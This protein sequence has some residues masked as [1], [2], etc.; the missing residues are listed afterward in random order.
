VHS[1]TTNPSRITA[2]IAGTH[3]ITASVRWTDPA[4]DHALHIEKNATT[5]LAS[6]IIGAT[7]SF[8]PITGATTVA[9]LAAD[10]YITAVVQTTGAGMNTASAS[11]QSNLSVAF[12]GP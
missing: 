11:E 8:V 3:V 2:P 9:R 1:N 5:I 4:G 6:N 12:I 7:S 10:D